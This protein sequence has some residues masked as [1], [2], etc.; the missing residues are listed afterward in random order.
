MK[1]TP[2]ILLSAPLALL[3]ACATTREGAV[4]QAANRPVEAAAQL[5]CALEPFALSVAELGDRA[6]GVALVAPDGSP[7]LAGEWLRDE[8]RFRADSLSLF[9]RYAAELVA[10]ADGT[11]E[12]G[13]VLAPAGIAELANLGGVAHRAHLLEGFEGGARAAAEQMALAAASIGSVLARA[14]EVLAITGEDGGT[15][16]AAPGFFPNACAEHA[17]CYAALTTAAARA[18]CDAAFLNNLR[19]EATF[20]SEPFVE[21]VH[22]AA[23]AFGAGLRAAVQAPERRAAPRRRDPFRVIAPAALRR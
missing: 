14:P 13:D 18:E 2:R 17:A 1:N 15:C 23:A 19:G 9:G 4:E 7:V 21:L 16:G 20:V 11:L 3:A 10:A 12:L 22:G 8:A 5:D 6:Y